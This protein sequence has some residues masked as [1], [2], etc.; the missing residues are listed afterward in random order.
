[1]DTSSCRF[2]TSDSLKRLLGTPII[3]GPRAVPVERQERES[4]LLLRASHDGYADRFGVIHQRVLRLSTDGEQLD[5]EDLFIPAH[6]E[7][8]PAGR[9]D[10]FA[11]RFHLHPS[12]KASRLSA[13]RGVM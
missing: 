1:N 4:T 12:I 13:G 11:A 6:G 10:Q 2:L 5:G 8:L 3:G 9:P 7:E